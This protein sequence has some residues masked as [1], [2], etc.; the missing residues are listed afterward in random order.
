MSSH[1]ES[2]K[3]EN[4]KRGFVAKGNR[5]TR[6]IR[7]AF[8]KVPISREQKDME[9]ESYSRP[10]VS[11]ARVISFMDRNGVVVR[12]YIGHVGDLKKI[13]VKST[14][15]SGENRLVDVIDGEGKILGKVQVEIIGDNIKSLKIIEGNK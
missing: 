15:I 2:E 4:Y 12:S 8:I 9:V 6:A 11:D 7:R 3:P 5:L 1:I 13:G 14:L 10:F